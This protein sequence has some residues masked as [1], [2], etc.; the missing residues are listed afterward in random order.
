MM[1]GGRQAVIY[2]MAINTSRDVAMVLPV[3]VTRESGSKALTF[4]SLND[5]PD[6]FDHLQH[7]FVQFSNVSSRGYSAKS[8]QA[9]LKVVKV[10]AF[11]ASYVP[12]IADFDR[13]DE[14]FRLPS[15]VWAKIP[16]YK[17]FGFA[18]FK[19]AA[20]QVDVHPMAFTFV[21]ATKGSLFFP[22]LHIHDGKVHSRERFDHTLYCQGE[23]LNADQW[24]ESWGLA[25]KRFKSPSAKGLVDPGGHVFRMTVSGLHLNRDITA[26]IAR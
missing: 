1:D 16:G 2:S 12:R 20:G 8:P 19:L 10:G 11:D 5:F 18:V 9:V 24:E 7:C 15:D 4:V 22:T 25:G 3:P 6:L 26:Q 23:A 17:D 13:L 21:T 14:R